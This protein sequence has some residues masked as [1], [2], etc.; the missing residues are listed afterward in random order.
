MTCTYVTYS[1]LC[2]EVVAQINI[3]GFNSFFFHICY[4]QETPRSAVNK[5]PGFLK[6]PG[7]IS[8]PRVKNASVI[9]VMK[10]ATSFQS[11]LC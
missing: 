1:H 5:Q 3:H 9:I 8:L 6:T 4:V 10:L 7:V 11:V 2:L